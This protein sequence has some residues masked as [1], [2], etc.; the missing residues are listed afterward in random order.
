MSYQESSAGSDMTDGAGLCSLDLLRKLQEMYNLSN[1]PTAFQFR[2]FGA[3]YV[4]SLLI[5]Y[6][7]ILLSEAWLC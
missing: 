6:R 2:T 4:M 3:K 7:L 1:L 5:L